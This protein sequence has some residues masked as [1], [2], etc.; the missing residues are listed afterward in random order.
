[1]IPLAFALVACGGGAGGPGG[2]GGGGG[3]FLVLPNSTV[4]VE[5]TDA[6]G[7]AVT[8]EAKYDGD[9]DIESLTLTT[10]KAP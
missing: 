5:G 9:G 6:A 10:N 3:P 7:E 4:N 2:P 8:A 1:M